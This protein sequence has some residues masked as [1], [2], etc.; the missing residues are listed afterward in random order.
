MNEQSPEKVLRG[1][2]SSMHRWELDAWAR[3]RAVRDMPDPSSYQ[4][5]VMEKMKA[6]FAEFCT[7]KERPYGR[8]GSFQKPPEYDPHAEEVV[9]INHVSPHRTEI[10]TQR[11]TGFSEKRRY[12]L[13]KE[14][15]RWRIDNAK[16][17][18]E[19]GTTRQATL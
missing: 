18:N 19:D 7:S 15:G 2:I 12:V 14:N 9:E 6:I 8:Q 3:S 4:A 5:E 1:F 16:A 10:T 11:S 13:L 17:V